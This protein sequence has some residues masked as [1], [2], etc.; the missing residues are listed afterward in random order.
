[1]KEIAKLVTEANGPFKRLMLEAL[2]LAGASRNA[3][4]GGSFTGNHCMYILLKRH[5]FLQ[6][7]VGITIRTHSGEEKLFEDAARGRECIIALNK[8]YSCVTLFVLS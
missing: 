5:L 8:F 4:H 1:M 2:R 6:L 3:Y 7:F